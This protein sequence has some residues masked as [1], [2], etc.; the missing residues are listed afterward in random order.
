MPSEADALVAEGGEANL[1]RALELEP[2]RVDAAVPYARLR[3]AAGDREGA[4]E[5]LGNVAGSFAAEGLATQLR[6]AD[7]PELAPA[8]EAL[9]SGDTE[10]GLDLLIEA[11]AAGDAERKDELRKVVVGVLDELGSAHPLAREARRKL[12]SA[13]Y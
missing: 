4:L 8:F 13:L 5:A 3:A 1:R 7:D 9:D 6:L 12:A 10:K 2:G 11:I